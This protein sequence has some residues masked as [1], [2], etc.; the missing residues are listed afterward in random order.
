[1]PGSKRHYVFGETPEHL[2][3]Q[4][5]S[6]AQIP[7]KEDPHLLPPGRPEAGLGFHCVGGGGTDLGAPWGGEK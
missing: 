4:P 3:P 5:P 1:M 2:L 6:W 7:G